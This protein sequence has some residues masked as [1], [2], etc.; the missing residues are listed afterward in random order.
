MSHILF[1]DQI[2]RT[3]RTRVGG[4]AVGCAQLLREGY[5]VPR[6]FVL[7]TSAFVQAWK[8]A[9]LLEERTRLLSL[10]TQTSSEN[11]LRKK[12]AEFQEKIRRI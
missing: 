5:P 12:C 11:I 3:D 4:K 7:T 6:G 2:T 10:F 8:E 1:L 9:G